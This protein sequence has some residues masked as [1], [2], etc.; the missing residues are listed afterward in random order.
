MKKMINKYTNNL[1]AIALAFQ[2]AAPQLFA[3]SAEGAASAKRKLREGEAIFFALF[4]NW[5]AFARAK[6]SFSRMDFWGSPEM[7]SVKIMAEGMR[8]R[9]LFSNVTL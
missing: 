6:V 1:L 9:G 8:F 3:G 5:R 2:L 4:A 7:R